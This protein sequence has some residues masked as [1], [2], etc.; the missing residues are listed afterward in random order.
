MPCTHDCH[1]SLAAPGL[2][3]GEEREV[4]E[5]RR[6]LVLYALRSPFLEATTLSWLSALRNA[7]RRV[8]LVG[9]AS[10]YLYGLVDTFTAYYSY[11]SGSN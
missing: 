10:D 2:T 9:A 3:A 6:K 1:R 5:R 11:T 8:P 7:A 4:A